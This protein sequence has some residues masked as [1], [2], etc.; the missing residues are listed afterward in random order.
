M[1]K[2]LNNKFRKY[3]NLREDTVATY[4][5]CAL[6]VRLFLKGLNSGQPVLL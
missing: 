6:A 2:C 1:L 5:D 3:I 4:Q